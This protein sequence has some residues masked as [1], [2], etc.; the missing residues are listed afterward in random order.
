MKLLTLA[1]DLKRR[2]AR[3]RNQLFVVEGLRSVEMLLESPLA[4]A[5][6]L[7][8]PGLAMDIRGQAILARASQQ[9]LEILEV[10]EA[11]FASAA[12]TDTPQGVLAISRTP[13]FALSAPPERALY[14]VLDAIQ[15]PGNVGTILRSAAAFGVTATLILPGTVDVWNAKVVRSTMGSI[16]T[17]SVVEVT[18][19]T[20]KIFLV[21]NHITCW[22]ADTQGTPV[23]RLET[24]NR[25][26][27]LVVSNEGAGIT[28]GVAALADRRVAISM[29]AGI[30]SLNVAVATGILLHA[31]R[32]IVI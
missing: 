3:E 27:A 32:N 16:F 1:R 22:A 2:K 29:S 7:V 19:E 10:R 26:L 11:E 6:L 14:L 20:L 9:N 13:S 4:I 30:E 12:N 23:D 18:S 25:R 5:G 28:S 24:T 15:D 21:E 17:Q 31:F 8:T